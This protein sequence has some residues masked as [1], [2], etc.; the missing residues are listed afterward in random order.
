MLYSLYQLDELLLSLRSAPIQSDG[1]TWCGNS[2]HDQVFVHINLMD[3]MKHKWER[4]IK[5][6]KEYTFC[7]IN[8]LTK[9]RLTPAIAGYL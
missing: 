4:P 1:K 5:Q 9:I 6:R 2:V 7:F 8:M 3:K